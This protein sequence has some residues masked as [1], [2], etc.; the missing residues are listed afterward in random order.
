MTTKTDIQKLIKAR[1]RI[2]RKL[3]D[4]DS[5]IEHLKFRMDEDRRCMT[6]RCPLDSDEYRPG[7]L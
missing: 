6:R 1:E 5:E 2:E 3:R 7:A 4:L